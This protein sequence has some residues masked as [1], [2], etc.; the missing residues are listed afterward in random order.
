MSEKLAVE[1]APPAPPELDA[2]EAPPPAIF[3]KLKLFWTPLIMDQCVSR[4]VKLLLSLS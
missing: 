2:G 1:P 3:P 4:D